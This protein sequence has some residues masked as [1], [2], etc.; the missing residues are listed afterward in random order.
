MRRIDL[1]IPGPCFPAF[2]VELANPS[3]VGCVLFVCWWGGEY[4]PLVLGALMDHCGDMPL[5]AVLEVLVRSVSPLNQQE[6]QRFG[7][8]T[9]HRNVAHRALHTARLHTLDRSDCPPPPLASGAL[10]SCP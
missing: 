1:A 5:V 6:L 10:L 9:H 4:S 3:G 2:C 8:R 7:Q